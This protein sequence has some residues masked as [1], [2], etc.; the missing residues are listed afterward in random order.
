MSISP[1]DMPRAYASNYSNLRCFLQCITPAVAIPSPPNK[2]CIQTCN[3]CSQTR[4]NDIV[5]GFTLS[6]LWNAYA[7]WSIYGVGV[8]ILLNNEER[9]VQYYSPS[10]SALQIYTKKPFSS[11]SSAKPE[12]SSCYNDSGSENIQNSSSNSSRLGSN[13]TGDHSTAFQFGSYTQTPANRCG[14]LYFQYNEMASPYDRV[15]L[16]EKINELAKHYPGL[17]DIHSMDLAPHSWMAVAWYPVYEVPAA[18][19]VKEL[20]AC[21]LTYHPL[22]S[23]FQ[24]CNNIMSEKE[25]VPSG[26]RRRRRRGRRS[27]SR[28]KEILLPPF[29]LVTYKLFGRMW[30]NPETS[31]EDSINRQRDAACY[32]L[33]QQQFQ[34]Q[35]FK[36]F[37]SHQY[38]N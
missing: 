8:P 17:V 20:S 5:E 37:M 31:D 12:N 2:K 28:K 35:D 27:G 9:V 24:G 36:F 6:E 1:W 7:E 25:K 10:L 3:G 38:Q 29:A 33:N 26:G 16:K 34:H 32:W 19:N 18:K 15:P 22:S 11:S 30:I 13:V 14:Y 23:S 4:E 21:F